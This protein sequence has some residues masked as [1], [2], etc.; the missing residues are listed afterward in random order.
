MQ[1]D[2]M[3]ALRGNPSTQ[4]VEAGGS[5]VQDYPQLY[6][7]SQ[8]SVCHVRPVSKRAGQ[9]TN[10]KHLNSSS[11]AENTY[12]C[13]WFKEKF[14]PCSSKGNLKRGFKMGPVC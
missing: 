11:V 13:I 12:L 14:K 5:Q 1:L 10:K 9:R 7:K 4:E 3:V 6:R 2:V 8:T